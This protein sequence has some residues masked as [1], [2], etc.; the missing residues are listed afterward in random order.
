MDDAFKVAGA[1]E[2]AQIANA[3][4]EDLAFAVFGDVQHAD[5]AAAAAGLG[6][7]ARGT[8]EDDEEDDE[9]ED[10]AEDEADEEDEE[11]RDRAAFDEE[12][13]RD[14]PDDSRGDQA[15]GAREETME[16]PAAGEGESTAPPAKPA[17]A[18]DGDQQRGP[19]SEETA[20]A[21]S[22]SPLAADS[23][24]A[25][26]RAGEEMS[27]DVAADSRPPVTPIKT[28]LARRNSVGGKRTP[29]NRPAGS[30][31]GS[32]GEDRRPMRYRKMED[33][34]RKDPWRPENWND[35]LQEAYKVDNETARDVYERLLERFPTSVCLVSLHLSPPPQNN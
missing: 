21:A 33:R 7:S 1:A 11:D 14:Q 20:K 4:A 31:P 13:D 3:E 8:E 35:L 25:G 6:S 17:R 34:V 15:L 28:D 12:M 18:A 10:E 27:V 26:D 16:A 2:Y 29:I 30:G 9:E 19:G 24:D 23:K 32:A 5:D 22:S